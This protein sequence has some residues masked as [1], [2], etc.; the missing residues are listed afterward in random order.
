MRAAE[1]GVWVMLG[2]FLAAIAAA[3]RVAAQERKSVPPRDKDNPLTELISGYYF[4]PLKLRALQDDDFDNPSFTWVTQ[5]EKLWMQIDGASQK[6]CNACHGSASE[7]MRTAGATYPK[8]QEAARAVVNLEQR[9]NICRQDKM[10]A[11][12]WPY[13]SDSMLAM[14]AFL[15]LQSRNTPVDVQADGRPKRPSK[16]AR[17]FTTPGSASS[18]CPAAIATTTTTATACVPSCS[19]R[20]TPTAT[21]PIRRNRSASSRCTSASATASATCARSP[22]TSARPKWWRWS[23]ISPGAARA[24]PSKRRPCGASA[25]IQ[26]EATSRSLGKSMHIKRLVR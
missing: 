10:K 20:A 22:M 2:L 12:P 6:S 15:K 8:F 13:G 17:S 23:C 11:T 5:G 4:T 25:S 26:T 1:I 18:A 24:S 7:S 14:T 3:P 21:P 16:S 9:V 19:A